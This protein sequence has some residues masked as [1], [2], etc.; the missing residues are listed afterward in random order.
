MKKLKIGVLALLLILFNCE[1][2]NKNKRVLSKSN[3]NI[4]ALNVVIDN[5]NWDNEIGET[6]RTIFGAPVEGLPQDE[7]LYSMNQ[8]PPSVFSGFATKNRIVLK[9]EKGAP[10]SSIESDVYARPQTVVTVSGNTK[11]EIINELNNNAS[12]L[13]DAFT[14][15]ELK[16]KQRRI[17]LSTKNDQAIE[18]ALGVNIKIPSAYRI[19]KKDDKFFWIRK[20]TSKK[21]TLDLL[22]YELPMDA[23]RKGD[24]AVIDIVNARNGIGKT[25]IQGENKDSYMIT[26]TAYAPYVNEIIIDNK[27]TLETKGLWDMKNDWMSGPF[28]N[29]AIEDK[30]NN[31]YVVLEGY[32]Y[33]PSV[34]KRDYMFEL[35][36]ILKSVEIK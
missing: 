35:E 7:P 4:N 10:N 3:G 16:E 28:I 5:E 2:G 1:D 27:P 25:H 24:S 29:Y 22:F 17:N 13:I 19:A 32:A 30:I 14:K 36:S 6:I 18:D 31:R 33:A 9:I 15:E 34:S 12:K 11:S 20:T 26:E 21:G 8:M 23:I